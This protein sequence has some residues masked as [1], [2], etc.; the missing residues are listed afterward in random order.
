MIILNVIS[1]LFNFDYKAVKSKMI[2][3]ISRYFEPIKFQFKFKFNSETIMRTI[4]IEI[5]MLIKL[6]EELIRSSS[7]LPLTKN[8]KISTKLS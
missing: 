2:E 5:C 1:L 8:K 7:Y 6:S 4:S 3:S